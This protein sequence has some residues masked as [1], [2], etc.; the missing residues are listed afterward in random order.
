MRT[1]KNK[2][3]LIRAFALVSW[4]F[5]TGGIAQAQEIGD[6]L[7]DYEVFL[8][9]NFSKHEV[10]RVAILRT[11]KEGSYETFGLVFVANR[12]G[13][14]KGDGLVCDEAGLILDRTAITCTKLNRNPNGKIIGEETLTVAVVG[15][16]YCDALRDTLDAGD[17]DK[18]AAPDNSSCDDADEKCIC[19]D[20]KQRGSAS[21]GPP[22]AGSGSGRRGT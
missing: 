22:A 5:L 13:S 19:Y 18:I 10:A 8:T 6:V 7:G 16:A 1:T 14:N 9:N 15:S 11:A 3:A 20:L 21:V 17:K 2:H 4:L 12:G